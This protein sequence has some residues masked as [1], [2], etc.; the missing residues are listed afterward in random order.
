MLAASASD[1]RELF[2]A[3]DAPLVLLDPQ[4]GDVL[5]ANPAAEAFY[6]WTLD[7]YR[8]KGLSIWDASGTD[9]GKLRE[10]LG[11]IAAGSL[12]RL[13]AVHRTAGGSRNVEIYCGPLKVLDRL[14][15]YGV[16]YDSDRQGREISAEEKLR[17]VV[18]QTMIGI[19]V[20]EDGRMAFVNPRMGEIFGYHA[21]QLIGKPTLELVAEQDRHLVD[22]N[23]RQ[24]VDGTVQSMRYEFRGLRKDGTQIDV[25]V[26]GTLAIVKGKPLVVG[27]LQDITERR[28]VEQEIHRY[29]GRLERASMGAVDA[30]VKMVE[31]RDPY[32]A[33][34]QHRVGELAASLAREL[35]QSEESVRGLQIAGHVHDIGKINVPSEILT[36]PGKLTH[37]EFAIIKTHAE[38]GGD[39]LA[40]IDFPWPLAMVA[41]QHHERLD[42]S[43]YPGG[44]GSEAIAPEARIMAVAD[45]VEAMAT[46]R[47]YRASLGIAAALE[48][49]ER[50]AGVMYDADA[51]QACARLFRD[52]RY[53]L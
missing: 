16:V 53:S 2:G 47:P 41:Q 28:R 44:L 12:T 27:V 4:S 8:S 45:V 36:K 13:L 31:L 33:G 3:G 40:N 5:A 46:H 26:H 7:E 30:I 22:H 42:G 18:E 11:R 25:G 9:V 21:D 15:L 14:C 29:I 19:Y 39:I 20:I 49:I 37:P 10:T 50:N 32:T 48:E 51:A 38:Q 43:G 17:A 35:G 23:I 24:R 52:N 6:G 1:L 34:H